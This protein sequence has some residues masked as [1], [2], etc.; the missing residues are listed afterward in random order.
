MLSTRLHAQR[1]VSRK[2]AAYCS[3]WRDVITKTTTSRFAE[4]TWRTRTA[5]HTVTNSN[6]NISNTGL[7]RLSNI[8]Q[9]LR[10][11]R[12]QR[13]QAHCT[14]TF[15]GTLQLLFRVSEPPR[16]RSVEFHTGYLKFCA[17]HGEGAATSAK[18]DSQRSVRWKRGC[19]SLSIES[20]H[21][22]VAAAF[23]N[24]S[25]RFAELLNRS[26]RRTLINGARG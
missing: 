4:K 1:V 22:V 14:G 10:S 15:R 9:P 18:Q 5:W 24:D 23:T 16:V 12:P 21:C 20:A 11:V 26:W 6:G 25:Q 19:G 17:G 2:A 3:P 13:T 7:N 8:P